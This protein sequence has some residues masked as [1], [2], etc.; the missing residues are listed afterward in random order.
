MEQDETELEPVRAELAD[1]EVEPRCPKCAD[2]RVETVWH[3]GIVLRP[4]EPYPCGSWP[5]ED[6][7]TEHLCRRC[8][9]CTYAWACKTADADD[10][11]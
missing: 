11:V 4:A 2:A 8:R 1:H 6:S 5:F 3:R 10:D 9:R 7:Q